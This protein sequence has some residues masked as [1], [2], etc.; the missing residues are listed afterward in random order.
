MK[1][2]CCGKKLNKNGE[3]YI[4]FAHRGY[5]CNF[6]FNNCYRS[7]INGVVKWECK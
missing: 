7:I 2:Q 4:A 3:Y 5:L 1:C 6:C